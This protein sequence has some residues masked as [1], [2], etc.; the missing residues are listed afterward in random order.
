MPTQHSESTDE[1]LIRAIIEQRVKAVGD[2]DA[3]ALLSAYAPHVLSFDVIDPLQNRGIEALRRRATEWLSSFEGAIG[4]EVRDL[5]ITTGERAAFCHYLF[6][7]GGTLKDGA[8]IGMYVR[9]TACLQKIDGEWRIIH[10]HQSV[11]FDGET[12]KAS[13]DLQP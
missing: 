6:R 1:T 4:Y 12:G 11:P 3:A 5:E 9:A 13:V 7:V 8:K 2:K 10:E